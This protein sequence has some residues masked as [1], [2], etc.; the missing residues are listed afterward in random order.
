MA[1]EL[2]RPIGFGDARVGAA[3]VAAAALVAQQVVGKALR[4]TLFLGSF[5]IGKLPYA[6][7]AA[8]VLSGALVFGLSRAAVAWSPGRVARATLLVSATLFLA[9]WGVSSASPHAAAAITYLHAGALS[10]GSVSVFWSLVSESFDPY[11]ARASIPRIMAGATLGGV[12]G[13]LVTWRAA[14]SVEPSELLPLGAVL[15]LASLAAVSRL[16]GGTAR[17][18]RAKADGWRSF[19]PELPYLRSLAWLVL[20]SAFTQA[21]LDYLLS[22]AA[23]STLGTGPRLLSFFALFQTGV[24]VLSFLL[25]VGVSRSALERLGVGSVLAASPSLLLGG[26]LAALFAPPLLATVLLRGTDGVLGASLHRSAYEV[27]FAPLEPQKKRASKPLLDVGF[28]KLGML[29]GSAAVA[30]LAAVAPA[31]GR[32]VLLAL[33]AAMAL[34]RLLLSPRLQAGYRR[35]LA[36]NLRRGRLGLSNAGVLDRGTIGSLSRATGEMGRAA[37][38]EQVARFRAEQAGSS[39]REE[40]AARLSIAAFDLPVCPEMGDADAGPPRDQVTAGGP[41]DEVLSALRDLRSGFEERIRAV[42]TRR[43]TE[44]LLAPQV[45]ALL[46]DDRVARDAA[47][48]LTAQE[49]PPMGLLGDAL[50]SDRLSDH[51]RRRVARLLGKIDDPR[52]ADGLLAALPLVPRGVRP[53]L[54]HALARAATR[55]PLPLGP[56]LTAARRAAADPARDDERARLQEVF[57]LLAAAYPREPMQAALAAL[58]RGGEARGTALEW[59]DVLLPDELKLALWPRIVRSGERVVSTPRDPDELRRKLSLEKLEPRREPD[60][61]RT[62]E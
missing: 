48:W 17:I 9:A 29:L 10:A 28:D 7:I 1:A 62:P 32:A 5:G 11:S 59:L 31:R 13:G 2:S 33:V 23:V 46:A 54:A 41:G 20:A 58:E 26:V 18:H 30:V 49:P 12:L 22:S 6:M 16:R 39:A 56:I 60:D 47:D 4:D 21:V 34:V 14:A 8:A 44:P 42:L 53:G 27:L 52:A 40:D 61:E 24:G 3:T 51:A 35:T 55:R 25:Q 38:L 45:V 36:E 15:N 57:S 50:L 19:V 43:R 37:L